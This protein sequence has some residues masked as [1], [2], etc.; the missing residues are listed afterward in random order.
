M[1][2]EDREIGWTLLLLILIPMIVPILTMLVCWLLA[3]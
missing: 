1:Y 3:L 2:D